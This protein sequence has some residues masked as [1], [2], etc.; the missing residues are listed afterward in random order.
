ME[1]YAVRDARGRLVARGDA[2]YRICI[3]LVAKVSTFFP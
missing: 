2:D 1:A 3:V